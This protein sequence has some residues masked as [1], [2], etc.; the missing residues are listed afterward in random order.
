MMNHSSIRI[1]PIAGSLGAEIEGVDLG[2][3]LSEETV[4]EISAALDEH[5]AIFFRDQDID[6]EQQVAF[7]RRFGPACPTPFVETMADHP[8]VIEII[9]EADEKSRFVF[10]GGWH[11]DFSFLQEPPYITC[12]RAKEVPAFGGDTVYANMILAYESLPGALKNA[13]KGRNGLHSGERAYSPKMQALQNLLENMTVINDAEAE[14][15]TSHPLVRVH[16]ATGR[17]GLFISPVYTVGI[18]G[19]PDD[20]AQALLQE[21]NRHALAEPNTCRFRWRNASVAV[22]DNRFTQHYALNDYPGKRRHM[23]RTTAGG[24]VPASA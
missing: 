9:K 20:E 3:S 24:P 12:L 10:G 16:P 21:L 4:A 17:A 19:M 7:T 1:C 8:E 11:S 23:F 18:E 22:W 6:L 14:V 5:L 2:A 13:I 15:V